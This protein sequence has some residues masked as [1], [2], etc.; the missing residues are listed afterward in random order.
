ML[1]EQD[2]KLKYKA[3]EQVYRLRRTNLTTLMH[4]CGSWAELGRRTAQSPS[5]LIQLA[6]PH[7]SRS[8]SENVAREIERTL[9]LSPN[10]LDQAH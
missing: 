5:F 6:G 2:R 7:P 1:T 3:I 10:W 9:K 8:I 4:L